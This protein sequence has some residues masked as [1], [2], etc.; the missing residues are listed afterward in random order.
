MHVHL[1]QHIRTCLNCKIKISH[2]SMED[3]Y[4]TTEDL[5]DT[6]VFIAHPDMTKLAVGDVVFGQV[7]GLNDNEDA[8]VLMMEVVRISSKGAGLR[9]IQE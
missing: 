6:G 1:R 8:P 3:I 4:A 7:Q 5:S 2:P 9:F